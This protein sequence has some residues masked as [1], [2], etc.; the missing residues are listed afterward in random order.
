MLFLK[1]EPQK[2]FLSERIQETR[3]IH[4]QKAC[5]E[6]RRIGSKLQTSYKQYELT[7]F[8]KQ[9]IKLQIDAIVLL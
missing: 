6:V 2:P 7:P 8:S 5:Y 1:T 3:Q 9:G 4:T